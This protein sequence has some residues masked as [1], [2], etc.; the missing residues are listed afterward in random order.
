MD[1]ELRTII[2]KLLDGEDSTLGWERDLDDND[3][4]A[5]TV[6]SKDVIDELRQYMYEFGEL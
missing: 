3:S 5:L 2:H 6:V 4:V 1:E